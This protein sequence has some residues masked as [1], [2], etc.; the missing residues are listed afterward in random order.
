MAPKGRRL[1]RTESIRQTMADA[2]TFFDKLECPVRVTRNTI[3]I[4]LSPRN[5]S[6]VAVVSRRKC[7]RVTTRHLQIK[8]TRHQT[9]KPG[10]QGNVCVGNTSKRRAL[11]SQ[12]KVKT[13]TQRNNFKCLKTC[14][15]I[16]DEQVVSENNRSNLPCL[17]RINTMEQVLLDAQAIVW[18]KQA[19]HFQTL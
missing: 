12:L 18:P 1:A 7:N 11:A 15:N 9:Q 2:Q 16:L 17:K 19:H 5:P 4:L 10:H 6:G 14:P 3:H 13:A 8:L